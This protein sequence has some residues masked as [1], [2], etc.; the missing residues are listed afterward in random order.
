MNIGILTVNQRVA[1]QTLED[2]KKADELLRKIA[3]N[4]VNY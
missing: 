3:E 4:N 2:E 1:G